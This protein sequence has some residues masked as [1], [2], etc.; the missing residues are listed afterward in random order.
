MGL[1]CLCRVTGGGGGGKIPPH[2]F[3]GPPD[4]IYM[5]T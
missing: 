3:D 5:Y 4:T 1:R 2:L